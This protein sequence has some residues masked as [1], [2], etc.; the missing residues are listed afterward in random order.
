DEPP[1]HL[2]NGGLIRDGYDAELDR[3]RQLGTNAQ[4]WLAQYQADLSQ[5]HN[6]PTVKVGFN[7]VFGY[8]IELSA[9]QRSKAPPEWKR[10]QTLKNAERYITPELKEFE[11]KALSAESQALAREQELFARLCDQ[12]TACSWALTP[13]ADAAADLDVLRGFAEL[14]RKRSYC[15]PEMVSEP[16]LDLVSA[17]HPVLDHTLADRY[18]PNDVRLR[19]RSA[20]DPSQGTDNGVDATA[21]SLALITGPNMAGKSTYI[22]TAALC[23]LLAHAGCFVPA[24]RAVIGLTDRI[25][26]RVGSADE[27]HTGRSTFMVEMTETAAICHHATPHS[28]VVLDEIGR[29]TSTLDGLSLAWAVA[30]HLA[31]L[32]PRTLFATHYHELTSLDQS[33]PGVANLHVTA[34]E[35]DGRVVFLHKVEPGRAD[36]SY[37]IHVA[38]LAGLP[39]AVVARAADLLGELSVQHQAAGSFTPPPPPHSESI[40]PPQ[41]PLFAQPPE[42]PV[43]ETLRDTAIESLS[44]L[45]AFDLLRRL[46]QE[47][48]EDA[49]PAR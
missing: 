49:A 41:M 42:H 7:K 33:L 28:L 20:K 47:L 15:R 16:A 8:Y 34:R 29:G 26:T 46:Q 43:V 2:R 22:R 48:G 36:R 24:D 13:Y 40:E 25:F 10:K 30:E 17:R 4:D 39:D 31:N 32:G 9:A 37:G 14:A 27:L 21:P 12:A 5:R 45:A 18:V 35:W 38:K 6:I 19:G 44:P 23:V 11:D 3:R 1:A